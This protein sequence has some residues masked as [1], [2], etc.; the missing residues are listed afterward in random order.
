MAVLRVTVMNRSLNRHQSAT[1]QEKN[2]WLDSRDTA[3]LSPKY[4]K[5]M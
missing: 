3:M 1:L 2:A 5:F 4:F